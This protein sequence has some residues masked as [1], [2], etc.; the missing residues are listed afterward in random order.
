MLRK[1][2]IRISNAILRWRYR[3]LYCRLFWYYTKY[4]STAEE[5]GFH[6]AEGFLWLTGYE[7]S[8]WA[9]YFLPKIFPPKVKADS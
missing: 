9:C 1:V 7:W 3:R 8:D 6:A 2:I 4:Y 5:A